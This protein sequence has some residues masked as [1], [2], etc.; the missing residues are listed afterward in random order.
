MLWYLFPHSQQQ[1]SLIS[2]PPLLIKATPE[3]D[4]MILPIYV[5]RK[6]KNQNKQKKGGNCRKKGNK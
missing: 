2:I 4:S 1:F 6:R 3:S 5:K